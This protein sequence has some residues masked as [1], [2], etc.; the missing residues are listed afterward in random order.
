MNNKGADQTA[1]FAY[2]KNR[3]SHMAK[4][5]FLMTEL[6]IMVSLF[7]CR[8]PYVWFSLFEQVLLAD[9]QMFY[10]IIIIIIVAFISRG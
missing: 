10:K 4:T 7:H 9:G 5:G 1:Q 2:G 6:L 3:F 8:S